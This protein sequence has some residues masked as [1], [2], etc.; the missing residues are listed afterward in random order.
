MVP[1]RHE[2]VEAADQAVPLGGAAGRVTDLQLA[3]GDPGE[4]AGQGQRFDDGAHLGPA[5]PGEHAGV[6][7]VG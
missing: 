6:D 7:E 5:E 4:P 1:T 3:D 2:G